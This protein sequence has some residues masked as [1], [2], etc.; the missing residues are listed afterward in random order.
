M[1]K[2][3][4]KNNSVAESKREPCSPGSHLTVPS[5]WCALLSNIIFISLNYIIYCAQVCLSRKSIL[6]DA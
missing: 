5:I 3:E 6:Q 2:P 1:S 4:S